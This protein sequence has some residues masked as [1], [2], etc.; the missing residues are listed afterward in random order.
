M[1]SGARRWPIFFLARLE[2]ILQSIQQHSER[3]AFHDERRL[4]RYRQLTKLPYVV[5]YRE[6]DERTLIVAIYHTSRDPD[7]WKQRLD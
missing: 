5:V 4:Y 3:G 2:R 7:W 6:Y 1:L